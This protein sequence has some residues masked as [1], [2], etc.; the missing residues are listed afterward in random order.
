M[1]LLSDVDNPNSNYNNSGF[2]LPD[3]GF[4]IGN[5]CNG[6]IC[7]TKIQIC[8]QSLIWNPIIRE[9]VILPKPTTA[10]TDRNVIMGFGYC[11]RTDRYK[12][13]RIFRKLIDYCHKKRAEIY[14][15]GVG[16][17]WREI[18]DVPFNIP[19]SNRGFF[20]NNSI[21]WLLLECSNNN[22]NKNNKIDN[23]DLI[24]GFDFVEEIFIT[25]SPPPIFK[26]DK[27]NEYYWSNLGVIGNRFSICATDAVRFRPDIQVWVMEQY[28]KSDSWSIRY[29]IRDPFKDWCN[30]YKWIQVINYLKDRKIYMMCSHGYV[31]AY[32]A[33]DRKYVDYTKELTFDSIA[34][35]P[36]LISLKDILNQR[37]GTGSLEMMVNCGGVDKFSVY[38]MCSYQYDGRME[39]KSKLTSSS[40][41]GFIINCQQ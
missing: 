11:K 35:V 23:F 9:F 40:E 21:H 19:S 29:S 20:F 1:S 39:I 4:K 30:P 13:V 6:L 28:G 38:F 32:N 33:I 16:L 15:L 5:S 10:T 26:S 18:G 17:Q 14:E 22:N 27:M 24:G 31:V 3:F 36:S 2:I 37:N 12:V 7:L 8:N 41:L 25:I 34:H